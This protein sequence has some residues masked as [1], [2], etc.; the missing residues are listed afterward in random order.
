MS[1][2]YILQTVFEVLAGVFLVWAIFHEETLIRFEERIAAHFR[3]RKQLR[4]VENRPSSADRPN[5]IAG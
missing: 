3:R 1:T 2:T 4:V 5:H